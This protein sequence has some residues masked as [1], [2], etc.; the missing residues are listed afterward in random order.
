MRK[1]ESPRLIDKLDT[2]TFSRLN[3]HTSLAMKVKSQCCSNA[4][5]LFQAGPIT[6]GAEKRD[7]LTFHCPSK[8]AEGVKLTDCKQKQTWR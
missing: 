6:R 1:R 4:T 2:C 8:S 3:V 7:E 5:R